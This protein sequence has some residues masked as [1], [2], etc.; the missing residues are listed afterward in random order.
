MLTDTQK[1]Y[2]E[3]EKKKELY[4]Q[5]IEELKEVTEELVQEVGLGGH[6]QDAEGT[7]YQAAKAV[8]RFVHFDDY[9]IKRT[10][11]EGERS[12]SLSLTNARDLGYEVK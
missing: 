6:F 5:F 9:E 10:R 8:G 4:K 2:I 7:V 3:L 1:R 11:R 12:G